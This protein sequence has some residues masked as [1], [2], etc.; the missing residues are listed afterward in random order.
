VR[1]WTE[2][3]QDFQLDSI[4][5]LSGNQHDVY[6]V[7]MSANGSQVVV[8]GGDRILRVFDTETGQLIQSFQAHQAPI[9]K[10]IFNHTLNLIIT[11]YLFLQF[12]F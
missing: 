5:T 12:N 7:H 6:S 11:W 10:A 3:T 2:G 4:K 1:E 9:C 8:G